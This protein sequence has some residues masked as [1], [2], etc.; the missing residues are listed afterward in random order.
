MPEPLHLTLERYLK[1]CA[2]VLRPA[3]IK[4]K[5]IAIQN[6]LHYLHRYHP[7]LRGWPQ[8]RRPHIEGWLEHLHRLPLK[9]NSRRGYIRF[10]HLFFNDLIAWQ[11]PQ[12]P[13]PG[14][15]REE[16]LPP[17]EHTLPKPLPRELDQAV[18]KALAASP[19]LQ[20]LALRLLRLTGMRLGEMCDLPL[21]A[22]DASN[23]NGATLRVPMGKTRHERVIPVESQAVELLQAILAQRGRSL[24]P[25]PVPPSVSR[26]LILNP[27]GRRL[28]PNTYRV[29]MKKLTQ[30]LSTTESL[31]PHRLRHTFATEMARAGMN[32]QVL[33][34]ILGHENPA[35]TMRYVHVAATDL[36]HHYEQ[37]L[38]KLKVLQNLNPLPLPPPS[39]QPNLQHLIDILITA[40]DSMRRDANDPL[41]ITHFQRL[42]KR[43]RK[44]RDELNNLL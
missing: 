9:P 38:A 19:S 31:H 27:C 34:K 20:A 10:V 7:T 23:P 37:A 18:Q 17:P 5:R 4:G 15:L 16:D 14:L 44:A 29:A 6:L 2:P 8:L 28:H 13:C 36:R 22:L 39:A 33:M 24:L 30:H 12:A 21:N 3:T 40:I 26:Y 35:M 43:I 42:A 32:L 11:W 25:A 41:L 1:Q